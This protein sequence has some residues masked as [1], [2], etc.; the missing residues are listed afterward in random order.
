MNY[1]TSLSIP[2]KNIFPQYI[3]LLTINSNNL[4]LI[5]KNI[6]FNKYSH[7]IKL[8]NNI[9]LKDI[10]SYKIQISIISNNIINDFELEG[11]IDHNSNYSTHKNDNIFIEFTQNDNGYALCSCFYTGLDYNRLFVSPP[12]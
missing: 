4:N 7:L 5:F 8:N 3:F 10:I 6:E 11:D 1:K 12:N 2:I 9:K